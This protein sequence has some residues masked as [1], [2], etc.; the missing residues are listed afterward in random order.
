VA[1]R[2]YDRAAWLYFSGLVHEKSGQWE[3]AAAAYGAAVA[4]DQNYA[5]LYYRLGRAREELEQWDMAAAAYDA[6]LARDDTR[7]EWHYQLARVLERSERWEEAAAAYENVLARDDT[8]ADWHYQLGRARERVGQWQEAATA[9]DAALTRAPLGA[10]AQ[11]GIGR[12]CRRAKQPTKDIAY[13]S[14]GRGSRF[15]VCFVPAPTDHV[16]GLASARIRCVFMA[17]ALNDH[18]ANSI[19]GRVGIVEKAG[20][21][22]VSQTC[23]TRT[24]IDLAIA[25]AKGTLIIYDC[26]DPYA[27]YEGSVYG[28]YAAR[29]F[30]DL[31]ALAD[32]ITVPTEGMRSLLRDLEIGKSVFILP[33][34][35]DY[36]EQTNSEP[37][38]P[39][40]SVIWFGNPG[41]GNF[42]A[43]AWALQALKERWGHAVTLITDPRKISVLPDFCVEP[44]AYDAFV[45]RLRLHGLALIS[46]DPRACHKSEN[47]YVVSITN[48]VAA[49]STGSKSIEMLLKESGFAEM[50]ITDHEELDRAMELLSDPIYRSTYI[51]RMQLII[52]ERFGPLAVGRYFVEGVLQG[53]L[54]VDLKAVAPAA[55]S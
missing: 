30:W 21:I 16:T 45:N 28:V 24:L 25:K 9:Y 41:R 15:T 22:V 12:A 55:A 52:R 53:V 33:D 13:R 50:S 42:K 1:L 3:K 49:I 32:A 17:K 37:V 7:A 54:G 34:T 40:Q 35:I 46:Q 27:D 20:A 39:T 29:R 23:T 48:G 18:F 14:L 31:A 8:R 10:L 43:G 19:V 5:E 38:P 36:Q 51:S 4:R 44:W 6:A 47:R 26:C 2:L 11:D